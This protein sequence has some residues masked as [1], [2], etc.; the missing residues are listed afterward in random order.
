MLFL[1]RVF[2]RA[3]R[4]VLMDSGGTVRWVERACG[5]SNIFRISALEYI[6]PAGCHEACWGATFG[7]GLLML[8]EIFPVCC[9]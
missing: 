9:L 4:L 7:L 8:D 5:L 3:V 1:P 6:M 2:T